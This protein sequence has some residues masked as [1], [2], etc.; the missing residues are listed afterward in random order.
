MQRSESVKVGRGAG[1]LRIM[2]TTSITANVV[3]LVMLVLCWVDRAH[4]GV[5]LRTLDS[6]NRRLEGS[7]DVV[8]RSNW[9]LNKTIIQGRLD[10]LERKTLIWRVLDNIRWSGE[11]KK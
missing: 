8:A 5:H 7:S 9:A 6:V 1:K 2:L 3:G 10:E 11:I 4:E